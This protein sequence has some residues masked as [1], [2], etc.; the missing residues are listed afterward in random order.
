[1]NTMWTR[2]VCVCVSA[3]IAIIITISPNYSSLLYSTLTPPSP[4]NPPLVPFSLSLSLF[5]ST[6][7]FPPL[8]CPIYWPVLPV[9]VGTNFSSISY[10]STGFEHDPPSENH[11]MFFIRCLFSSW[12]FSYT[13]ALF[14]CCPDFILF[15]SILGLKWSRF[16]RRSCSS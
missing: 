12:V 1:M 16:L 3:F 7:L 2:G 14:S 6:I 11:L 4:P 8:V 10:S 9:R 13:D 15:Y 5:P